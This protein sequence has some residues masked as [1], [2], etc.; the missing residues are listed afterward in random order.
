MHREKKQLRSLISNPEKFVK[1]D[2]KCLRQSALTC[3]E[4]CDK[5]AYL[6]TKYDIFMCSSND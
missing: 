1:L 2:V 3:I 6:V 5:T 4:F